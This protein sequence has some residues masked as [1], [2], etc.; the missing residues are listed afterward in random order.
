MTNIPWYIL[1][2]FLLARMHF[3]S[4]HHVSLSSVQYYLNLNFAQ[5]QSESTNEHK[6]K[7]WFNKMERGCIS[8]SIATLCR[9]I[10]HHSYCLNIL[11]TVRTASQQYNKDSFYF[12]RQSRPCFSF[13]IWT[14]KK[15]QRTQI[16]SMSLSFPQLKLMFW[17]F[18]LS[19]KLYEL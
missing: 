2:N 4:V 10:H 15:T 11:Q 3:V 18:R 9:P 8:N 16:M 17:Y 7:W 14:L 5:F 13:S 6:K 19:P 12:M 1:T